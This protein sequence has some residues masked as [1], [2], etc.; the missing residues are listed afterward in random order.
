M[1]MQNHELKSGSNEKHNQ[2]TTYA[3][4]KLEAIALGSHFVFPQRTN[5]SPFLGKISLRLCLLTKAWTKV[6]LDPK[7]PAPMVYGI[8]L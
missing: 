7:I 6:S 2:G 8:F 5:T 4:I 1:K 3:S